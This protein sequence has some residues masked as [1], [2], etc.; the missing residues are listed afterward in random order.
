M[1][2][3]ANKLPFQIGAAVIVTLLLIEASHSQDEKPLRDCRCHD[4]F[5]NANGSC[6]RANLKGWC[7]KL[8]DINE[9]HHGTVVSYQCECY[10]LGIDDIGMRR[11]PLWEQNQ[12]REIRQQL[13][14]K[15]R[16][17]LMENLELQSSIK[18]VEDEEKLV[19][20]K[21]FAEIMQDYENHPELQEKL[22]LARAGSENRLRARVAGI[23]ARHEKAKQQRRNGVTTTT[24]KPTTT[25]RPT[26]ASAFTT[27]TISL[28][29][30]RFTN[31]SDVGSK[32][33]SFEQIR[34]QEQMLA[35]DKQKDALNKWKRDED[36]RFQRELDQA[37]LRMKLQLEI[38]LELIGRVGGSDMQ[39]KMERAQRSHE[40]WLEATEANFRRHQ[41]IVNMF[42]KETLAAINEY[43]NVYNVPVR[44]S[45]IR[46]SF[47]TP[48]R[49]SISTPT[50]RLPSNSSCLK[51]GTKILMS[52][53]TEKPVRLLQVGDIIMDMNLNPTRVL[54]VAHEFLL[55]QK[56]FGFD[57]QSFF[58]TDNHIFVGPSQESEQN[59]K[60][61]AKSTKTLFH[62]NPLMKYLNVSDMDEYDTLKLFHFDNQNFT[63]EQNNVVVTQDPQEYPPETLI[64]FLQVDSP[65]GTYFANG[66]LCR[67]EIPP[68]EYWPNT[69]GMLFRLMGTETFE[70]LAQLPY[71]METVSF[72]QNGISQVTVAVKKFLEEVDWENFGSGNDHEIMAL[73]DVKVDEYIGK[74]FSNPT[75]S[76]AGVG[77]Y[78]R[79]GEIVAPYLDV[80]EVGVP[81]VGRDRLGKIQYAIFQLII[82]ELAK[83]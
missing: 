78:A 37:R 23:K 81:K 71:N 26:R 6:A 17:T 41:E 53:F 59:F 5:G 79:V 10:D 38:T 69:M 47:P 29:H 54:G 20:E 33:T 66:Y 13:K 74:I 70:N 21:R 76:T 30:S 31:E 19:L 82:D 50:R 7:R 40:L 3:F 34:A 2:N 35:R 46:P 67:H 75:L 25:S 16:I 80:V 39:E 22:A 56:F 4:L 64:Y 15:E 24:E 61:Y 36:Q 63:L 83:L 1:A 12:I 57:N 11:L 42:Y 65:T 45:H 51:P 43:T 60:L 32:S 52:D 8:G 49:P 48:T 62:N 55:D 77:L 18:R 68:V 27:A 9:E 28:N 73:D 14:L 58:F 72:L 44:I